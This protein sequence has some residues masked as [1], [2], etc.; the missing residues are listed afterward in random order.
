M[1]TLEL[2]VGESPSSTSSSAAEEEDHDERKKQVIN[3]CI[4]IVIVIKLVKLKSLVAN[5]LRNN[6]GMYE[7]E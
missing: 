6:G 3:M 4:H 1:R 2:W 5:Q 7:W